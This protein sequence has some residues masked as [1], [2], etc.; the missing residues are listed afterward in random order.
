M[1]NRILSYGKPSITV[2][3]HSNVRPLSDLSWASPYREPWDP[4]KSHTSSD[5]KA[6]LRK[7]SWGERPLAL[8][9]SRSPTPGLRSPEALGL[10]PL[11]CWL[12]STLPPQSCQN[13]LSKAQALK[14]SLS[15]LQGFDVASEREVKL[16]SRVSILTSSLDTYFPFT[17]FEPKLT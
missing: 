12:E 14:L 5:R 2:Q 1:Q 3:C 10:S 6:N 13:V 8:P 15:H 9:S 17:Y 4:L 7:Q 11:S 16:L